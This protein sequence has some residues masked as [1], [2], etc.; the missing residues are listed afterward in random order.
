[1]SRTR[2]GRTPGQISLLGANE[3]HFTARSRRAV[4]TR[5]TSQTYATR[6][7]FTEGIRFMDV[8]V[9]FR[10]R[11]QIVY[12]SPVVDHHAAAMSVR[13]IHLVHPGRD[14]VSILARRSPSQPHL[15]RARPE[16]RATKQPAPLPLSAGSNVPLRQPRL[17]DPGAAPRSSVPV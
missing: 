14:L 10:G 16:Q 1:M 12:L 3:Q 8:S 7:T 11:R 5:C 9:R 2:D 17:R 4:E 6:K 13:P 15:R